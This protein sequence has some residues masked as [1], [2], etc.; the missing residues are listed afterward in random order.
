MVEDK[1]ESRMLLTELLCRV[2]AT[3][4]EA[5]NGQGGCRDLGEVG[6]SVDLDGHEHGRS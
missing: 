3:V 4:R 1:A 6:A 2:G 5:A